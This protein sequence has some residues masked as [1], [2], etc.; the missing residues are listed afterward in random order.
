MHG[1]LHGLLRFISCKN[2]CEKKCDFWKND[3]W[4]IDFQR[5]KNG[6]NKSW[7]YIQMA[8]KDQTCKNRW[9]E[10]LKKL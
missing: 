7:K 10:K 6:L 1:D 9:D 3:S 5:S 2:T 4:K 8:W